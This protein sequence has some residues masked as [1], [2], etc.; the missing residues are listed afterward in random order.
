MDF[1]AGPVALDNG[2]HLLIGAYRATL[3][4]ISEL[5]IEE[6]R[7][8][9]RVPM[10]LQDSAGRRLSVQPLPAPLHLIA[11]LLTATGLTIRERWAMARM[12]QGLRLQGWRAPISETVSELLERM[13]QPSELS[14]TLWTPLCISALN[15]PPA[16]ACARTFARVLKE[17]LGANRSASD[18]L[19]P[20]ATL[21]DCLPDPAVEKLTERGASLY[22][23]A[24]VR[25]IAPPASGHRHWQLETSHGPIRA[26]S[27]VL[28][29][30]L[31]STRRL[32]AK[33]ASGLDPSDAAQPAL[34]NAMAALSAHQFESIATLWTAWPRSAWPNPLSPLMLRWPRGETRFA[35]W[36]FDRGEHHGHRL[37]AFVL[38][39][40]AEPGARFEPGQALERARLIARLQGLPEPVR[41]IAVIERRATFTCHPDR[42]VPAQSREGIVAGLW[43]AGDYTEPDYPATLEAAV[44]SGRRMGVHAVAWLS[45]QSQAKPSA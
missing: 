14:R 36:F 18:F 9:E 7:I 15:T 29:C 22:W 2:Q 43:F 13:G 4:L 19:L 35:D 16:R 41:A 42:P 17:S 20:R 11:G 24:P 25:S 12:I 37:G 34:G 39:D 26:R 23:H 30:G 21:S 31:S 8:F 27:V 6:H 32:L 38:S 33:V 1:G 28:A 10:R 44:L 3:G 45:D 5:G 40:A